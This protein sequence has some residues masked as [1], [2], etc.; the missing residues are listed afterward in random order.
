MSV[1]DLDKIR[2]RAFQIWESEGHPEGRETEHW[3]RAEFEL[4]VR[5]SS[6]KAG[7][8]V[9]GKATSGKAVAAKKADPAKAPEKAPEKAAPAKRSKAPAK[10]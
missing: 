9:G 7:T 2:L 5:P 8:S 1:T 6:S 3:L 4:G 10:I